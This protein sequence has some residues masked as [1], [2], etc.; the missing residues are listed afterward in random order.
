MSISQILISLKVTNRWHFDIPSG[1]FVRNVTQYSW[2]NSAISTGKKKKKIQCSAPDRSINSGSRWRCAICKKETTE[3]CI[4][5]RRSLSP[6][7]NLSGIGQNELNSTRSPRTSVL[8]L[9]AETPRS[10]HF[11]RNFRSLFV[12]LFILVGVTG[13]K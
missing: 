9:R 1:V 5:F 4:L 8:T 7:R 2:C 13:L 3:T 6:L 10:R 11:R 12:L